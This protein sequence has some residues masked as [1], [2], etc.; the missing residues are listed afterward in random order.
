[1]LPNKPAKNETAEGFH[2]AKKQHLTLHLGS[3]Y[4]FDLLN[5]G[6]NI[7]AV[8]P[9]RM[10]QIGAPGTGKSAAVVAIVWFA[11]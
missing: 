11:H 7:S 9:L 10:K 6:G 8:P 3:Q 4:M 2:V 1:M 5:K